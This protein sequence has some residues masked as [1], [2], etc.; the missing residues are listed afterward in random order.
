MSVTDIVPKVLPSAD[1]K[2]AVAPLNP[3]IVAG[4]VASVMLM[5]IPASAFWLPV[6]AADAENALPASRAMSNV[7]NDTEHPVNRGSHMAAPIFF[8]PA[9]RVMYCTATPC[10]VSTVMLFGNDV[11]SGVFR[12]PTKL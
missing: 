11:T 4:V 10:L 7:H 8:Y 12:T 1:V 6:C 9:L 2:L 5:L 3:N